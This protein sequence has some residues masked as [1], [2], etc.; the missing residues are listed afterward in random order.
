MESSRGRQSNRGVVPFDDRDGTAQCS[1]PVGPCLL[2]STYRVSDD[3]PPIVTARAGSSARV[4][5]RCF[6]FELLR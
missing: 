2:R 6:V 1:L 3:P 5:R 4:V